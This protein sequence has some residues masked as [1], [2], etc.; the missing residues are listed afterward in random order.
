M[1]HKLL[2]TS[3]FLITLG[4]V[5]LFTGVEIFLI[6]GGVISGSI[7]SSLLFYCAPFVISYFF[8][9]FLEKKF[10]MN[11]FKNGS[12]VPDYLRDD[13]DFVKRA[14]TD[15]A[16]SF[17][18]ASERL[19]GNKKIALI[20]AKGSWK[21]AFTAE[22][23]YE[24][25]SGELRKDIDVVRA[26]F[27]SDNSDDLHINI[28]IDDFDKETQ[29]QVLLIMMKYRPK[30]YEDYYIGARGDTAFILDA[31]EQNVE[32]LK[33][34]EPNYKNDVTFILAA[35]Q[36][37]INI[38]DTKECVESNAK[39]SKQSLG[40]FKH[41]NKG[42][43]STTMPKIQPETSQN[44]RAE[45]RPSIDSETSKSNY[46]QNLGDLLNFSDDEFH[47]NSVGS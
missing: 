36:R 32:V 7:S 20:S 19:R 30:T 28:F 22:N 5:M 29:K 15:Y 42:V 47:Q 27:E 8:V 31:V 39:L 16:Q 3:R 17:K 25:V 35:N 45:M 46:S 13:Y 23:V 18:Y 38:T 43:L 41:N 6:A 34:V 1:F 44:L 33:Y 26:A 24:F 4:F 37:G 40:D 12:E 21:N 11:S 10:F 2:F 9:R 14:V